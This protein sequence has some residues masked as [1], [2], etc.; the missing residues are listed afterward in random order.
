MLPK[1][2]AGAAED[3][4]HDALTEAASHSALDL[5]RALSGSACFGEVTQPEVGVGQV[6]RGLCFARAITQLTAEGER[7][8]QVGHGLIPAL[9]AVR[10][11]E[12]VEHP[13]L[14]EPVT[15]CAGAG[16]ADLVSGHPIGPMTAP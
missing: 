4:Q 3:A 11:A 6:G 12:I 16:Q 10:H 14:G 5:E 13:L 2:L 9:N 7:L 1:L 15:A 8:F